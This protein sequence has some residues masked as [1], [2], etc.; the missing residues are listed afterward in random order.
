MLEVGKKAIRKLLCAGWT[1]YK[2]SLQRRREVSFYMLSFLYVFTCRAGLL[3]K[4]GLTLASRE[5]FPCKN[6]TSGLLT[7]SALSSFTTS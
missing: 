1:E 3:A 6:W 7:V 2:L 5:R 4:Q